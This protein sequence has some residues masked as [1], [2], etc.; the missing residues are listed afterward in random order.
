MPAVV[1]SEIPRIEYV[2]QISWSTDDASIATVDS[3][4]MLYGKKEGTVTIHA[5]CTLTGG[6]SYSATCAVE[7]YPALDGDIK[8]KISGDTLT[9]EVGGGAGDMRG[10]PVTP[11]VMS[12]DIPYWEQCAEYSSVSKIIV[13]GGIISIG[14]AA[15][16]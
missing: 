1:E 3:H 7:V 2:T 10:Y 5:S 12:D 16:Y 15:F 13:S 6:K 9:L 8:W 11:P 14:A 4:G